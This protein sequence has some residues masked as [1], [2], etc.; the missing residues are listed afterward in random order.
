[1]EI[2]IDSRETLLFNSIIARD[3]DKYKDKIKISKE[4]LELGDII[5][6]FNDIIFVYERKTVRD[7]LS[8]IKDGRYNEQKLRLLSNHNNINYIIEGDDIISSKNG[9]NQNLLSS[10][11]LHSIY[12][13][14]INIF[15]TKTIEETA[16]FILILAT[17]IFD[18]PNN[19]NSTAENSQ[20]YI[21]NIKIKSKKIDNLDKDT[22]YL[23][24]LS[25]IPNI[26]KEIAKKIK[27]KYPTLRTLIKALDDADNKMGLLLEID[28][29]GEFKAKKILEY[30]AF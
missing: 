30:F 17:K 13:D 24:Q 25:Q 6:K 8:S 7:L 11:Y 19:F 18:S 15:F 9:H 23:L 4:Q 22:C 16:T 12:R 21:D 3:L 26:S 29:I 1:M 5:I 2:I 10:I 20:S 28:K 14:K 27:E